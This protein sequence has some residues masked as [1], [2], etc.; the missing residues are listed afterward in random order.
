MSIGLRTLVLNSNYMPV[1]IFPLSTT[2]VE[3]AMA[4]VYNEQGPTCRVVMEYPRRILT[5]RA[6]LHWPSVISRIDKKIVRERVSL[7]CE[8]LYYRDHG[9]CQYCEKPLTLGT[10]TMDHVIPDSKG[11]LF[12]WENIVCAC[13]TCNSAKS[14]AMPVGQWAPKQKPFKPT[15]FEL[16]SRRKKFPIRVDDQ[17]WMSFLG[18]WN[19]EVIVSTN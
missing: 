9:M 1:S 2:P 18:N 5:Q 8:S 14:D 11:G 12:T 10:T 6:N 15:Y 7:T 19:A 13:N 16:L 4:R 3:E 17:N